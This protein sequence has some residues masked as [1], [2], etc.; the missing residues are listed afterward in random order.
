MKR[1]D[2]INVAIIAFGF[3]L[4]TFIYTGFTRSYG[5]LT[6]WQNQHIIIP[7][8]FRMLFYKTFDFFPDFA[9]NMGG[10]QNIYYLSYYGLFNP[11]ILI[12]YLLPFVSMENYIVITSYVIVILSIFLFYLWLKRNGFTTLICFV[13]T[14][15]FALSSPIIFHSHRHIM[16]INYIPFILLCFI[17][18]DNWFINKKSWLITLGAFL[19][20]MS[21]YFFSVPGLI[22]VFLYVIY[23]YLDL[24]DKVNFKELVR[25]C[26]H[27]AVYLFISVLMSAV[28]LLPTFFAIIGGRNGVG[29]KVSASVLI[30]K[31]KIE[32]FLYNPYSMGLISIVFIAL[33]ARLFSKRKGDRFISGIILCAGALPVI[34]YILNGTLYVNTKVLIP[35]VP[36]VG[37]LF[38]KFI[39]QLFEDKKIDIKVIL[40]YLALCIYAAFTEKSQY[41]PYFIIDAVTA[42]ACLFA[43]CKFKKKIILFAQIALI[44]SMSL[45]FINASEDFA[46]TT[47]FNNKNND[48]SKL[49]S[50]VLQSDKDYYRFSNSYYGYATV[51]KIYNPDYNMSTLYSS[52]YNKNYNNFYYNI[53]NNEISNRNSVLTNSTRNILFNM[54]M[55]NKYVIT[56]TKPQAGYQFVNKIGTMSIYKNENVLPIG[57]VSSNTLSYDELDSIKYPYSSEALLK[58]IVVENKTGNIFN[59]DIT[60]YKPEFVS[61]D[62]KNITVSENGGK[63]Y[64]KSEMNGTAKLTFKEKLSGKILFIRF[65]MEYQQKEEEGDSYIIIND[66]RNKLTSEGSNYSN[67]NFLFDYVIS[68]AEDM[69]S[70]DIEF[71]KGTYAID[72]IEFYTLDY[73]KIKGIRNDVDP[74]LI[75]SSKTKGDTIAGEVN[76]R[77]D[78][79]FMLTVP[80]DKGF[81]VKVDGKEIESE[82][83]NSAFLGFPIKKGKHSI[84]I[85]YE[86]PMK[87]AGI[88]VSIIGIICYI[89]IIIYQKKNCILKN[90]IENKK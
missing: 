82:K 24:N 3:V 70:L 13:S 76:A 8:Y 60:T 72:N 83:V 84:E 26:V 6:D 81:V 90:K 67:N 61:K 32:T 55:G 62:Y 63:Y 68:S 16:F 33:L 74:L 39:K 7:E 42:V 44:G 78:G 53:Y 21:S 27:N 2:Y 46:D 4:F 64:I 22:V 9:P 49:V 65:K 45:Y 48:I 69:N 85:T 28:L 12:S 86:A 57:F 41:K 71:N 37:F 51:N 17:G 14:I 73:D 11:Y 23:K 35:F 77:N 1:K 40:V 25:V 50:E 47:D 29:K 5:S 54:L 30:P 87:K 89:A 19:M 43:F 79:Y 80:Y 38:A 18:I 36:L 58:N 15:A 20:I 66:V 75:D 88:V 10:G 59:S 56:S 34:L 31:F 52:I